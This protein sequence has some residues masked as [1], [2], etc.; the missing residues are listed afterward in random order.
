M[1][2]AIH[3][4]HNGSMMVIP[5]ENDLVRL[6]IQI[7]QPEKGKRPN[8]AEVT[9]E[10]LLKAAQSILA[11]YTIEMPNIE[12]VSNFLC[13]FIPFFLLFDF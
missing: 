13:V 12:W 9:P 10:K 5:R 8:R 11:P 6:Y 4:A 7:A 2:C 3:S 1:R